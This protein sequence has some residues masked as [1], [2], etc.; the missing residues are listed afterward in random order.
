MPLLQI[1][2]NK[3]QTVIAGSTADFHCRA[4]KGIPAPEVKWTRQDQRPLGPNIQMI[5]GGMMRIS[6]VTSYD[7]GSYSCVAQNTVGTT[8]AT[9]TLE[10]NSYPVI[11]I[12]PQRGVVRLKKGS[13]LHLVCTASGNPQP[14]VSWNKEDGLTPVM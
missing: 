8:S 11:S 9:V 4:I 12:S 3:T 14:V 13:R 1:F 5:S 6:N 2:P 7:Q 10:V